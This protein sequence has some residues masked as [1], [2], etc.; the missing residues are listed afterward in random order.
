MLLVQHS[1]D[2]AI[3]PQRPSLLPWLL[4]H[5]DTT[6]NPDVL[7]DAGLRLLFHLA[8]NCPSHR[9]PPESFLRGLNNWTRFIRDSQDSAARVSSDVEKAGMKQDGHLG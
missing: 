4:L 8:R 5:S 1:Y 9:L 6:A 3:T 7:S 2:P